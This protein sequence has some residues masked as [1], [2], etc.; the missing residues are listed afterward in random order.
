M[1]RKTVKLV[2]LVDQVNAMLGYLASD[3]SRPVA[4]REESATALT[5]LL[6]SVLMDADAYAGFSE[7]PSTAVLASPCPHRGRHYSTRKLV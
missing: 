5:V 1:A 3:E 6:E 4:L 2:E 7:H